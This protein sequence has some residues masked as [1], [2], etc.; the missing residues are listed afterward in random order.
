[1]NKNVE[2]SLQVEGT[3][4]VKTALVNKALLNS[5]M[6][7]AAKSGSAAIPL[8]I[9]NESFYGVGLDFTNLFI[10]RIMALVTLIISAVIAV[11]TILADK[12]SSRFSEMVASPVK[13][14]V[15]YILGLSVFAFVAALIVLAYV[16]YVMGITIVGDIGS[17]ALLMLLI[18][19]AGV[20]LGV[21]AAS[22]ARTER[23]AFGLF[24]LMI[25]LQVLFGGLFVPVARFDYYVQLLSY[26]LPLTYG[27]DAM[28][29]VVIRGF[30][31]GDVGTDLVAISAIIIVALVLAVVCLKIRQNGTLGGVEDKKKQTV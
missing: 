13:A 25:I 4:Q 21:L 23:Q 5:T 20:S 11:F 27:L 19:L 22:F 10:Y 16:I 31:L 3:D 7:M 17:V 14:A 18:A 2:V 8:T 15:A 29:S 26:S 24:G 28:K 9:K 30:S 12:N 6:E 1:V